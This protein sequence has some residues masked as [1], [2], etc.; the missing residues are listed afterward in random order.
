M[1]LLTTSDAQLGDQIALC[2]DHVSVLYR[3]PRERFA[4]LKEHAIRWV[5]RRVR[6]DEFWALRDVNVQVKPGE[7]LGIIGRN[8]AGK[9]T[10]LK[11]ISR[12]MCPTR[13]NVW[14]CGLVAPLLELGAGFH[15]ELTGRE[16]VF[17]NG[18]LLGHSHR[19]IAER[20]DAIV[21]F[22]GV[23]EFMDVPLRTYST[24]MIARLGFAVATEWAPDILLLDEVLSVGDA[25]FQARCIARLEQF[26]AQG[27]TVV[28]VSHDLNR[29]QEMCHRVLW[30]EGGEVKGS[31]ETARVI[32][33]YLQSVQEREANELE[34]INR[35]PPQLPAP[36]ALLAGEPADG[37]AREDA[38]ERRVSADLIENQ[39]AAALSRPVDAESSEKDK[40]WGSGEVNITR[41]RMLGA[42]GTEKW[43]VE[44]GEAATL[45]LHY[46]AHAA[47]PEAVFS[48]TIHRADGV[49]VA[50]T[51]TLIAG[52]PLN[53]PAGNGIVRVHF[54]DLPLCHG[55]YL[56]SVGVFLQPDPPFW[57]HPAD[58]HNKAYEFHVHAPAAIHGLV[59]IPAAWRYESLSAPDA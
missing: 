38:S 47:Q 27:K 36:T 57:T 31:G 14:V 9:S 7:V 50:G 12:V 48:A 40:R 58:Y 52:L 41:V 49:Y 33:L 18:A 6:Y 29:L 56:I 10:L 21:D 1:S 46:T 55:R 16:N 34:I 3:V 51:N 42:D 5:Q 2:L 39:V 45:A 53:L 25:E 23:Q 32:T 17:L 22:A 4:T 15:L 54:P 8:G 37:A 35:A 28:I 11:V 19:E 24:G 44:N 26:R 30:M 43:I 13:G 20:F 59:Q